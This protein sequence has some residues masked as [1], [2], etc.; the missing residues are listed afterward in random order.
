MKPGQSTTSTPP[1][2][3]HHSTIA[4][5]SSKTI[6][7]IFFHPINLFKKSTANSPPCPISP[8]KKPGS[9]EP[10]FYMDL[11]EELRPSHPP[12]P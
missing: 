10:G 1:K 5:P 11:T 3:P 4:P 12:S 8:N 9:I 7:P 6:A 2:S